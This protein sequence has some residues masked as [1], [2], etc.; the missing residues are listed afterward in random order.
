MTQR[1]EVGPRSQKIVAQERR[2]LSPGS[3]GFSLYAG[4][5]MAR[6][7]DCTLIDEDG[8]EYI[9]FI[10]GIA[11]GSVG[12]CHPHYVETLKRQVERL[13]FGSFTTETRAKFLDLVASVTPEGLTRIQMFSGG[14]EAVE[15]ALRLAQAAS[16]KSE[17][18]GFWGGFHG[19]TAGVLPLL[20]SEFKHHLG[21]FVP[22]RYLSPYADCYRCPLKLRYPDC[23][24]ACAEF[25]RDVIRYQTGGEIGAII[26]EPMQGTA[27]NIIPPEGF[28]RAIQ[29]IAREHDAL[30]ISDEMITGFGRTGAMWGCDHDGV[31]PDIMTVGKGMGGGF[32]LAA[33]I[34]SDTLTQAKPWSNP[35][36]ASSSYGG[37]PLAAAA[38]LAALEIILKQDL[39]KNAE[40]VGKVMLGRLEALKEKYRCVGDVRGRGLLLGIELVRDRTTREPLAKTV[41][42]ALYQECLR[43]GLVAMTYAP[44]VRINPPLTIREDTALAGLAILDEALEA[45]VREHGLQ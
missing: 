26:V 19:K 35:S 37:N 34:S 9:D 28:L 7:V 40:R 10:A 14:A 22:G 6:G 43:R 1:R 21:P 23:G 36:A 5:A 11:V 29:A 24:I 44:S 27:G 16:G 30:L 20:G 32:P 17:V 12:H 8:N 4:L 42:Q 13:T 39:V 18:L 31:V 15:A 33:V 45:V 41:T 25:V 38:G 2:Y 3:Q